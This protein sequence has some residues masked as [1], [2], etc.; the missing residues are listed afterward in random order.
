MMLVFLNAITL[1]GITGY[2]LRFGGTAERLCALTLIIG[3][4]VS[5]IIVIGFHNRW[6]PA[7]FYLLA[8]DSSALIALIA[9]ALLSDRFWPLYMAAFQV[10][11]V[12]THIAS[13]VDP[14]IVTRAYALA[15]GFWIYP[16]LIVLLV[17]TSGVRARAARQ[18]NT[19]R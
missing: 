18:A 13:M 12:A 17:G 4:I 3:S 6:H 19:R 2:A 10:P 11:G 5:A 15:Q 16:M 8:T 9:V 7:S 14:T 1:F